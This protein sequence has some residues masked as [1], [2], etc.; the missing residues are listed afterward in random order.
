M[1]ARKEKYMSKKLFDYVIGN[2]PYQKEK[3][4]KSNT[5]QPIYHLFMEEANKVSARTELIHPARFLFNAGMTPEEWNQKMLNDPHFKVLKYER[6]TEKV[7]VGPE[8]KG[9]VAITYYDNQKTYDPIV[10]YTDVPIKKDILEKVQSK[11]DESMKGIAFVASKFDVQ[12]LGEDY[13]KYRKHEKRMS[14]NVLEFDCFHDEK[15]GDDVGVFG[16]YKNKR[17]L[18]YINA[19]YVDLYDENLE[20]YKIVISKASGEGEFGE[21]LT[22]P[23]LLPPHVGFT[24]TFL[25]LGGFD[26]KEEADNA[27]KYIKT[28]FAR[29]MLG[30]LK[31]TQ[32]INDKK[33]K[34]IPLQNFKPDSD[35]D[36]SKSISEIDQQLYKKYELNESEI[37]FIEANVKEMA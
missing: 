15:E 31:V 27:L 20:K 9:G 1:K 30:V 3:T 35:I 2:P 33:L 10:V 25:G 21:T 14:S 8:I 36:W 34:Y 37:N 24:H 4:G 11:L 19:K 16:K 23:E 28:K 22:K 17:A 5:A 26:T 18:R 12:K 29:T 13:P 32:D 7:F 6:N